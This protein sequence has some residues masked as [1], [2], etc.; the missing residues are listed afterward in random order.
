MAVSEPDMYTLR[1]EIFKL[2]DYAGDRKDITLEDVKLMAIPTIKSIIFD[3]W[4]LWRKKI[5][6]R[7]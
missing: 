2:A 6:Q 3:L 1:N 4:M 7:H 5:Y